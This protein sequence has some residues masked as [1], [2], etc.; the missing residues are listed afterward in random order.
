MSFEK[1]VVETL[2]RQVV[3][4][5]EGRALLLAQT[6]DTEDNGEAALFDQAEALVDD[7]R[8]RKMIA[9]H[10]A[11]EIEHGR[12]FRECAERQGVPVHPVPRELKML[13]HL[14]TE[15]G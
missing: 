1:M 6:A 7:P 2:M 5:P 15:C 14:D 12:L 8:F 3:R 10:K 9:R 13:E 4:T 11:D